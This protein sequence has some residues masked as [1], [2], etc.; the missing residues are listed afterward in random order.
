[1]KLRA[2][3]LAVALLLGAG[4]ADALTGAAWD[5]S[6]YQ[7]GFLSEDGATLINT[8]P[9]NYSDL[10]N[11][12]TPGAGIG[13]QQWGTMYLN[14]ANGS[15]NT[16][17]D[18]FSDPFVP[19]TPNIDQNTGA[20]TVLGLPMGSSAA[21]NAI[22]FES[23]TP[24]QQVFNANSMQALDP[25]GV[26]SSTLSVVFGLDLAQAGLVG[27]GFSVAFG[28]QI[29]GAG[30][31][32]SAVPVEFSTDG[33]T[34]NPIGTA[35]LTPSAAAFSFN[36][37]D[38]GQQGE[39]FFRLTFT[40]DFANPPSVD[41]VSIGAAEVVPEPGTI[42]LTMAGLAGIGALGRRRNA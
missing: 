1:M 41:N 26:V 6:Q 29:L 5:F 17:L 27:S 10:D 35:N 12:L 7:V 30:V 33:S 9:S 3:S 11:E 38:V 40:P 2:L 34:Y 21:S 36:A 20:A 14:G 37:P 28:G 8:L 13:S 23:P 18:G 19:N 16:P 42:V 25:S 22:L 24:S 4:S 31:G 39:V 15:Y 32:G